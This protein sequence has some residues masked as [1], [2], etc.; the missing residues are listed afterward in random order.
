MKPTRTAA[1]L[2][3]VLFLLAWLAAAAGVYSLLGV[4]LPLLPPPQTAGWAVMVGLLIAA[5]GVFA[6]VFARSDQVMGLGAAGSGLHGLLNWT[7]C[8][9]LTGIFAAHLKA[10]LH[11]WLGAEHFLV[12]GLNMLFTVA[13]VALAY[14]L[15]FRRSPFTT[16]RAKPGAPGTASIRPAGWFLLVGGLLVGGVGGLYLFSVTGRPFPYVL[17]GALPLVMGISGVCLGLGILLTSRRAGAFAS[18]AGILLSAL[19]L[20]LGI[21][22]IITRLR[23]G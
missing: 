16:G 1:L 23:S 10:G 8:G 19:G 13:S 3:T 6:V 12:P 9:L 14:W 4:D 22:W 2:N 21:V 18:L 15:V 20:G 11:R 7:L 5:G 17:A